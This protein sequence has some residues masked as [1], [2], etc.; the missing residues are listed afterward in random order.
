VKL[1]LVWVGAGY[2]VLAAAG[3]LLAGLVHDGNPYWHPAP[4]LILTPW[5]REIVSLVAGVAFAAITI[6]LTRVLVTRTSW[7]RRLHAELR[8]VAVGLGTPTLVAMAVFSSVGEELF[9][10]GFLTAWLGVLAQAAIFGA[11]HQVRG[12]S[13]WWWMAWAAVAG[14][15]LGLLFKAVGT[16]TGPI[17]AHALIN[18]VNLAYLRDH[19]AGEQPSRLGGLLRT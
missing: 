8:P 4:W 16:L 17:V 5:L 12:P 19:P 7:A 13:R 15:A 10:R 3:A 1:S 11:A 2:A 18:A 14:L 6:A 9:F